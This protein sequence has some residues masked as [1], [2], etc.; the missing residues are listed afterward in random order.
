[1]S[2]IL[3]IDDD[4]RILEMLQEVLSE[5]GHVCQCVPDGSDGLKAL[6]RTEFDLVV[7]DLIMPRMEGVETIM[8]MR[9]RGHKMPIL[10]IS[11]GSRSGCD[12]L[13]IAAGTGATRTLSKPFSMRQFLDV[14]VELLGVVPS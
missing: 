8:T 13:P 5:A 9:E 7:T 6:A 11:G 3:I 4:P 2:S 12:F 10:A 14:V 1:L